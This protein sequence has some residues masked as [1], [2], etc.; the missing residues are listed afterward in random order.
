MMLHDVLSRNAEGLHGKIFLYCGSDS[1]SYEL[2][3]ELSSRIAGGMRSLGVKKGD[4]V[5]ILSENRVDY[6]LAM[7]GIFKLGAV[8]SLIDIRNVG[9]LPYY[10]HDIG[11]KVLI[12][13]S[14]Q[15]I[16][17]SVNRFKES[18]QGIEH[19]ISF[20]PL[21]GFLSWGEIKSSSMIGEVFSGEENPCHL[22]Y[23]SGTTYKSKGVLLSHEP[24][25][26]T[27]HNISK[28]LEL[29]ENDVT[30][31]PTTLS[32]SYHL[33]ANLL[34]GINAG[35]M[36]GLMNQWDAEE[37]WHIIKE[38]KVTAFI[39]NPLLLH[40]L[41]VIAKAEGYGREKLRFVMSG[42]GPVPPSLKEAYRNFGV[43][44]VESYGQ[45]ELGGFIALGEPRLKD[46]KLLAVGKPL[47][48]KIV[49]ILD[50]SDNELK[51]GEI[52]E[53]AVKGKSGRGFMIGYKNLDE[54]TKKTLRGDWLHTSDIGIMDDDGNIYVLGRKSE[55]IRSGGKPIFPRRF[56][57]ALY[58]HESVYRASVIGI[59]DSK[60]GE[61][62][63][64]VVSV[65]P[66]KKILG[67]VLL[68]FCNKNL[69]DDLYARSLRSFSGDGGRKFWLSSIEFIPEM[70]M[71]HTGKISKALLKNGDYSV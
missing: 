28:R 31:G 18:F 20:D 60:L 54:E 12:I 48:D 52:G 7:Y 17:D 15:F 3:D 42:G 8:A 70:P 10:I 9:D 68:E 34:P 38:K 47:P 69:E 13:S 26:T 21:P 71:T 2:A 57:E 64:A 16:V 39:G 46:E 55:L 37:A 27:A 6:V 33:V 1:V 44:L 14:Q 43:P 67:D 49:A 53:I 5:A 22:A 36:L 25:A 35:A 58:M 51:K 41:I 61:V 65:Y 30:L 59:S 40:D 62:P 23:T 66:N 4:C 32:S 50:D 24:T 45:S 63:H 11:P 29:T 56:E 19:Y